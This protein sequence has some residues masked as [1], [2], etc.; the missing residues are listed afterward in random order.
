MAETS[1]AQNPAGAGLGGAV[2]T[3][4]ASSA[5][6]RDD[7]SGK[8]DEP[9]AEMKTGAGGADAGGK[10]PS[11]ISSIRLNEYYLRILNKCIKYLFIFNFI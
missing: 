11:I 5:R 7:G 6:I 8:A 9:S 4:P 2:G 1:A 10:K 3:A